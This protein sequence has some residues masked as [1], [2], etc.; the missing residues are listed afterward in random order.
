MSF[1]QV[2]Q[3]FKI[4]VGLYPHQLT[5]I[6][7]MRHL[8]QKEIIENESTYIKYTFGFLSDKSGYGKTLS[9]L[10]LI[11]LDDRNSEKEKNEYTINKE[12]QG[13]KRKENAAT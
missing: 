6:Y 8:E 12:K 3:P 2:A 4:N 7:N 1:N 5:S 13:N 9:M 11:S 10:G